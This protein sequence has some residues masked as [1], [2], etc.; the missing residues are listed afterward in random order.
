[1]SPHTTLADFKYYLA[2]LLENPSQRAL[3]HSLHTATIFS[4]ALE[5]HYSALLTL[6]P[7][8]TT[9]AQPLSDELRE[10]DA[11]HDK[12]LRALGALLDAYT[13]YP[14]RDGSTLGEQA[15]ALKELLV[16]SMS[17]VRAS[18]LDE[19]HEATRRAERLKGSEA[20]L[21]LFPVEGGTLTLWYERAQAAAQRL[22]VLLAQRAQ[23]NVDNLPSNVKGEAGA[24]RGSIMGTLQLFR[25]TVRLELSQRPDMPRDTEAR[26][27][28]FLDESSAKREAAATPKDNTP[29]A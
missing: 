23:I 8:L 1:V 22:G 18:Y 3:L 14:H 29:T 16:P 11:E 24:L 6:P 25:Q 12:A 4:P 21:A 27:F 13:I 26:L 9:E 28:R 5:K 7:A 10:A 15:R 19:A 17:V 20:L 2:D